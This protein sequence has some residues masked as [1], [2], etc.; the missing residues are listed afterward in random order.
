MAGSLQSPPSLGYGGASPSHLVD[1]KIPLSSSLRQF[2]GFR[3]S[4]PGMGTKTKYI[5]LII[6][7]NINWFRGVGLTPGQ[8]RTGEECIYET[9]DSSEPAPAEC[10]HT[11]VVKSFGVLHV[12]LW[13]LFLSFVSSLALRLP[14]YCSKPHVHHREKG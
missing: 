7:H 2:Q 9:P 10:F 6:Y 13:T 4:V 1:I 8:G 11:Q 12:H 3:S 5:F 14:L